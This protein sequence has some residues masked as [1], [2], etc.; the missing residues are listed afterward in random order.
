MKRFIFA[1]TSFFV[2][3]ITYAQ[4]AN[5]I[6]VEDLRPTISCWGEN[7]VPVPTELKCWT[8]DLGVADHIKITY[9]ID[10]EAV[11][12]LDQVIIYEIDADDNEI[13]LENFS[14]G[15][16][17]GSLVTQLTTGK[18]KIKYWGFYGN[19]NGLYK[20]FQIYLE[21]ATCCDL[22]THDHYI[23]GKLGVG[24]TTPQEQLHVN[25]AIRGGGTNGEVTLKG[26]K[27]YVTIGATNA[28]TMAFNTDK[29]VFAFNKPIQGSGT[30][31]ALKIMS[32]IGG[33]LELCPMDSGYVRF[34]T[35][36]SGYYFDKTITLSSGHLISPRKLTFSTN[37]STPCM[38]ILTS[39][40]VGIGT[41]SPKYKLDVSGTIRANEIIVNTT[42]ADF[43]FAEDYQLRPL[44]EVKAFI[45]ENKHLPEIKPARDMQENGVG[46]N[47]LQTQLLQKIEELTLYLIQQEQT[48]Q[49][50]RQEIEQLKK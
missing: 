4:D 2:A 25:G 15:A 47:E 11:G 13:L 21:Q 39:G 48:I 24:T 36:T 30:R 8:I 12:A 17:S 33:Y 6:V 32:T 28:S 46:V 42:G 35:N 41:L 27:G 44:S 22:V 45:R 38:T 20:G 34:N 40:Y 14:A 29:N 31:G 43:V 9:N 7:Y 5:C 50:L 3:I 10:L 37:T 19:C 23:L 1:I 16:F 49:E 18:L 26:D